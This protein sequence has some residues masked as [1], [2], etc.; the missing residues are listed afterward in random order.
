M[1]ITSDQI[2]EFGFIHA[3]AD[4]AAD[5]IEALEAQNEKLIEVCR[6]FRHFVN[7]RGGSW[8]EMLDILNDVLGPETKELFPGTKESLARLTITPNDQAHPPRSSA[9]DERSE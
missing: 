1:S 4:D 6:C 8:S 5:E 7:M 2:R 9:A 3:L